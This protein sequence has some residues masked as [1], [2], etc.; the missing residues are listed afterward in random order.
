M[1]F[2]DLQIQAGGR[3]ALHQLR[4]LST[5]AAGGRTV[6]GSRYFHEE[7]CCLLCNFKD[8]PLPDAGFDQGGLRDERS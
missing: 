6:R 3:D 8:C 5:G 1:D 7:V 2:K 4:S